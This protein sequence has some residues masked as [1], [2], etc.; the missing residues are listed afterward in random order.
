MVSSAPHYCYHSANTIK[1]RSKTLLHNG[2]SYYNE[3]KQSEAK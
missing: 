1:V 3:T 2:V